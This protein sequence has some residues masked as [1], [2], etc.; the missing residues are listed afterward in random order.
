MALIPW[1]HFVCGLQ[2][3]RHLERIPGAGPTRGEITIEVSVY[4][5]LP[6]T[7]QVV[8]R[9]TVITVG[10]GLTRRESFSSGES[11]EQPACLSDLRDTLDRGKHHFAL[12]AGEGK[13]D[14]PVAWV[15]VLEPIPGQIQMWTHLQ[16]G[17]DQR[18]HCP[19][20]KVSP[21]ESFLAH[22]LVEYITGTSDVPVEAIWDYIQEEIA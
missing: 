19:L 14:A 8:W 4:E 10:K 16:V 12:N 11:S 15:K 9:Y 5:H 22:L 3:S 1:P 21:G 7:T 6:N 20:V 13:D 17:R 18:W 2:V